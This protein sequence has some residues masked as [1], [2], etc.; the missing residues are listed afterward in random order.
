MA[1]A[2]LSYVICDICGA[3]PPHSRKR[4]LAE[5][6]ALQT[7]PGSHRSSESTTSAE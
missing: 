5:R 3:P 1:I 4:T 2:H 7:A 6:D